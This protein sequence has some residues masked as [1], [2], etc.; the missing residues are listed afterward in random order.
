VTE[1]RFSRRR[2]R[3][4]VCVLIVL[5]AIDVNL[6]I[7]LGVAQT[8]S[9]SWST[10]ASMGTAR[11]GLAAATGSDGRIYVLGGHPSPTVGVSAL[12]T[13]E[14]YDSSTHTWTA[15]APMPTARGG[16]AASA[17]PDGRIY[18]I[19]GS[20]SS[21][22]VLT[23]VEAYTPST[24]T[25]TSVAS[26]RTP[27]CCFAAATGSDG[28][29]YAIG[30]FTN[31]GGTNAVEA[32]NPGTNAWT[33]VA[34]MSTIRVSLAAARGSDGRIYA[35]G[36]T[37]SAG[38]VPNTV[39]AY[40]PSTNTWSSVAS[41]HTARLGL[42]AAPAP[43][44]RIYAAGGSLSPGVFFNTV[45]AYSPST[46]T[47]ATVASMPT[48]RAFLAAATGADGRVYAMGGQTDIFLNTVEAY[49]VAL[50]PT[51]AAMASPTATAL[52]L[53][54]PTSLPSVQVTTAVTR[55]PGIPGATSA[56]FTVS[57]PSSKPGQGEVYFG[58]GPGCAGLVEVATRDL[59]PNTTLHTVLVTGNDLPGSVG[60]NGILP[61]TTYYLEVITVTSAGTEVN[62]AGGK[63]Y[64][65]AVPA[66]PT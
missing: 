26:M 48:A 2:A 18:A 58:S 21:N 25:W 51:A 32:Y 7:D 62:D 59:H 27:R 43:D 30:G 9:N 66:S 3:R 19:G 57:F 47:W 24:N 55:I 42:A 40:S 16:L 36:G 11:S 4:L 64:S 37:S 50:V 65:V 33:S 45:E 49:T 8:S 31:T 34:P 6:A 28:R 38:V 12:N 41:M 44:G 52:A 60:D 14:A 10:V 15:T 53:P 13:V 1:I 17:G 22:H 54:A 46:N 39:E 29:I 23:A 35:I 56:S 63:C 5:V 61:G 20:D